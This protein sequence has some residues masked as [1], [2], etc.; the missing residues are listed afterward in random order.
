VLKS[1]LW[2]TSVRNKIFS[3]Y[4]SEIPPPIDSN[5]PSDPEEVEPLISLNALIVFSDPQTLKLIGYIK[6]LKIII[7][8]DSHNT[9]NFIHHRIA[10]EVN[11]MSVQLIISKS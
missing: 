2:G 1:I 9:R 8:D 10:Q 11:S 6:H 4:V 7:L 3:E 5:P